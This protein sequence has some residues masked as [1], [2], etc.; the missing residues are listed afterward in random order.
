MSA[1]SFASA[2]GSVGES[3]PLS[4]V[5]AHGRNEIDAVD[6]ASDVGPFSEHT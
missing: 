5:H 6:P 4:L 2:G 1:S 3:L